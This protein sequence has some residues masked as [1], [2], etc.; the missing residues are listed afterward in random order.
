MATQ[1]GMGLSR[2][3]ILIG[4]GFTGSLVFR[5]GREFFADI[6]EKSGDKSGDSDVIVAQMRRLAQEIS[7]LASSHPV[8]ILNGNSGQDGSIAALIVPAATVGAVGYGYMWWKGVSFSDMMY[9]TKCNM[10]N[11]V[12]SM[13]NHLEKVSAALAATKKHLTQ[14]IQL[15]DDKLDEQKE[16]STGIKHEVS[17]ACSKLETIDCELNTLQQLVRG[18]NG[19]VDAIEDKQEFASAGISYICNFISQRGAKLP[20]YLQLILQDMPKPS[21]RRFYLNCVESGGLKGLQYAA[22]SVVSRNLDGLKTDTTL[23]VVPIPQTI[24]RV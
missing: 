16:M 9:V 21:G 14:R 18:L 12:S 1:V 11:A 22:E 20:D 5:N 8:T 3:L 13:A 4:A 6:Q 19:K 7:V 24:A 15:L 10:A 23:Q 2:A 17:D